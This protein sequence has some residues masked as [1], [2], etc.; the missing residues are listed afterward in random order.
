MHSDSPQGRTR[1]PGHILVW[2]PFAN[3]I[4]AATPVLLSVGEH[5]KRAALF[6]TETSLAVVPV[7]RF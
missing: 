7:V 6:C 5:G 3:M 2:S 4:A 1:F